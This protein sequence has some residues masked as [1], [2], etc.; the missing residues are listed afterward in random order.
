MTYAK[1]GNE[2]FFMFDAVNDLVKPRR[3][4]ISLFEINL[5]SGSSKRSLAMLISL[6]SRATSMFEIFLVIIF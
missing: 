2:N 4:L 5:V 3:L 1:D 6:Y